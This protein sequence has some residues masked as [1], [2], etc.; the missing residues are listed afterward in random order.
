[1]LAA[2]RAHRVELRADGVEAITVFGSVARDE[3][4]GASDV[5]L[6]IRAGV[7]FSLGA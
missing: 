7:G 5:D 1:M 6:A 4:D 2:L 3:A